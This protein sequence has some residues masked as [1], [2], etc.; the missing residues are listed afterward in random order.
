MK[1]NRKLGNQTETARIEALREYNIL[2]TPAEQAFDDITQMAA[3]V[4]DVPISLI[5]LIDESREWFKSR[6]GVEVSETARD[7]SFS[8]LVIMQ[9][10]L[11]VVPDTRTDPRFSGH[12]LVTGAPNI[13]FYAGTPLIIPSHLTI[14]TLCVIDRI[15]RTMTSEQLECLQTLG[16]QIIAQLELRRHVFELETVNQKLKILAASDGLTELWNY[17]TFRERLEVEY[18]RSRRYGSDL[19]LILLDI[20]NFKSYNDTFGHPAGDEV[21]KNAANI[22]KR[23][24]RQSD[25]AARY[26]GEEFVLLLPET[27]AARAVELAERL[28]CQITEQVSAERPITASF[29]VSTLRPA[30]ISSSSL[31]DEADRALYHA[32]A[33]GKNRM[34]H[35][36]EKQ[37]L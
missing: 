25:V 30:S 34:V 9:N 16:R 13:R 15:P 10:S 3:Y 32:K 12:P 36:Y 23:S 1:T 28:R 21:L 19:S 37:A 8:N 5:S 2:D 6:V 7:N 33:R 27:N 14:G 22:L 11:L 4:C 18:A 31:V 29:G 26:G 20:D 35:C 24:V 17:R